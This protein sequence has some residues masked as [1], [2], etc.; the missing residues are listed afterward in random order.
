MA[1]GQDILK[2]DAPSERFDFVIAGAG[3]AGSVLAA[4]LSACGR[5]SVLLLEAGP[6]DQNPWIHIPVGVTKL[7]ANPSV[8]WCF[9]TEPIAALNDRRIYQPR[10]K[11]LGGTSSINGMVYIR[12]NPADYDGW[13]QRGC[14]GWDWQSVLPYFKKS[15]CQCRGRGA[16]HGVDGPLSVSDVVEPFALSRACVDAAIEAGVPANNDFNGPEQ[17]GV[18]FYQFTIDGKSRRASAARAFLDAKVRHRSNLK[19]E[20][21]ALVECIHI[22]EGRATGLTF[23]NGG[24]KKTVCA[25]AEIIVSGG[26]FG[27]PQ[28]LQLSGIGP[29]RVLQRA[30]VPVKVARD[31][32]GRNLHDHFNV[33]LTYKCAD[34]CPIT[35]ND[36]ARSSLKRIQAGL[37]YALNGRG[38]LATSGVCAGVFTR[39]DQNLEFPDLQ[40]NLLL[41]SSAGRSESGILPHPF[42][43]FA[44]S[45]VHLRSE[46]RGSVSIV[47]PQA[48]HPPSIK[49][50]FLSTEYERRAMIEAIRIGRRI[51][52]QQPLAKFIEREI[53]PGS[54][55]NSDEEILADLRARGI[56]NY[57]P[58]GTCRMGADPDAVVDARLR[59]KGVSNL[60]VADASIMPQITTGNTNAPSIMIGEKAADMIHEDTR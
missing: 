43:A 26:V 25:N 8:N 44:F 2:T 42:S 37:Q 50:N 57:H 9:E 60:R 41:Y 35:F 7:F 20:T 11:V 6:A 46:S 15:E 3:S 13:Q 18:G 5:F 54:D 33:H 30:G 40:I 12:G 29:G 21:E 45:L 10:G 53:L 24:K 52:A 32:V 58:V 22:E 36:L 49:M 27:S 55:I 59:V 48:S 17:E 28:I 34:G 56:A 19:I 39:T 14:H 47:S 4:R 1:S 31:S 16:L 23:S 38:L 51:G